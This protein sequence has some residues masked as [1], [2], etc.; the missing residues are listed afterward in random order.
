MATNTLIFMQNKDDSFTGISVDRCGQIEDGV[1]ELL[2]NYYVTFSEVKEL[3]E[4]GDAVFVN[5]TVED[6][7]FYMRDK[8]EEF[9]CFEADTEDDVNSIVYNEDVELAYLFKN[10]TW[11]FGEP[12]S[13]GDVEWEELEN[14]F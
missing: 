3:I 12:T 8:D 10:K 2:H 6:S 13:S 5:E 14:M 7:K 1:G 9:H 4:Q 11:Y